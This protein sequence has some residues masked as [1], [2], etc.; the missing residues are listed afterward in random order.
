[1]CIR[2]SIRSGIASYNV[3]QI[4]V[5]YNFNKYVVDTKTKQFQRLLSMATTFEFDTHIKTRVS[6]QDSDSVLDV[7]RR[8]YN[9]VVKKELEQILVAMTASYAQYPI[10]VNHTIAEAIVT[11]TFENN[12]YLKDFLY[13]YNYI[14]RWYDFEIGGINLRDVVIFDNSILPG[15]KAPRGLANEIVKISSKEGR[16]GNSTQSFYVNRISSY[17]GRCV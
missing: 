2:D 16:Q 4:P 7:Y 3:S 10:N 11:E 8:N 1:M 9:N 12:E 14:D 17:T 5:H 13:A 15:A 6:Q